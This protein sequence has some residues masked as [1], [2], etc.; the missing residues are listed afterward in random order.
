L[1]TRHNTAKY[2]QLAEQSG[3]PRQSCGSLDEINALY[4]AWG[5]ER[6]AQ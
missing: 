3:L 1:V 4:R 2:C 6:A 5:L